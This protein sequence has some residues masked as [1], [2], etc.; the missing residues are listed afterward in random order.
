MK[1]HVYCNNKIIEYDDGT[2]LSTKIVG[3]E[4]HS[5]TCK[6]LDGAKAFIRGETYPHKPKFTRLTN[7]HEKDMYA[8]ENLVDRTGKK[9]FCV[10]TEY[11]IFIVYDTQWES[12]V[13]APKDFNAKNVVSYKGFNDLKKWDRYSK[14]QIS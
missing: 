3:G 10:L 2:F 8:V 1:E 5:K 12:F 7:L 9:A 13:K 11:G 6:T 4:V 14:T